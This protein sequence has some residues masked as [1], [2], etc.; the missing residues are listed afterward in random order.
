MNSF[1][2]I[3]IL[4]SQLFIISLIGSFS[5][6]NYYKEELLYANSAPC[7]DSAGV[8]S[9]AQKLAPVLQLNCYSC[10][11]IG[12]PSGNILLGNY[13][14][15]KLIAQNGKLF[16]AINHSSG[17][18]AMPKNGTKLT[19][20]QIATIKKWIDGGMLNN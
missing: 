12:S 18:S 4:L 8:V 20:C 1:K 5:S 3:K 14:A 10:H 6:C 7:L 9:Y 2:P 17:F 19:N 16:G 15:D 11:S 13:A